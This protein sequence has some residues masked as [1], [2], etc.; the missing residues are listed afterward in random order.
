MVP[1]DITVM[2]QDAASMAV[3]PLLGIIVSALEIRTVGI[4]I[5]SYNSGSPKFT[6]EI[7]VPQQSTRQGLTD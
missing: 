6:A 4:K 7:D 3:K 1:G 2:A 5:T